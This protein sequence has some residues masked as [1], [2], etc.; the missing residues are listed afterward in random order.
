MP[1]TA[2][3]RRGLRR[4]LTVLALLPLIVLLARQLPLLPYAPLLAFYGFAVLTATVAVFYLAYAR[5]VD[6]AE[7]PAQPRHAAT[8]PPL[9]PSPTVSLLVAV[10]DEADGIEACVRS[11]TGSGYRPLQVIVVDDGSTDGTAEVLDRLA[12]ELPVTVLHLP[13]NV[14][15]KRALVHAARH[16]TGEVLAFTDSDCVLAPD[17]VGRCV[18]ALLRQPDLGAVSGHARALN[19]DESLLSRVQDVWY[20]GQFRVSKAAEASFGAVTCVSGPLAVFRREAVLNYLPAWAADRFLGGEFRFATDRQLTGYVLGQRWIGDRLKRRFADS[21]FVR[22][23]DHPPRAWRVGYVRSAK[24]WTTVP[25]RLRPF[26]RQQTRWKK[27]YVRN[28]FFTGTF[29]WRRGP[30]PAALYYGHALWVA[31]APAMAFSH[32][33]WAPLRG[34][35]AVPLLYLCGVLLKGTAWGLAYRLDNPGDP[36]WAYRPLMS[37][38]SATVLSWLLPWSVGTIRRGV[39]SRST[40]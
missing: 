37:V 5:Y 36:R 1:A 34:W 27:S 24:V 16:A 33:V 10:K 26:L 25:A 17:A 19:P 29:M 9:P 8:F 21:P 32:L 31:L 3:V 14:G 4:L 6:P 11:M 7:A 20:E 18:E 2:P 28:L 30:G 40:V 23:E 35:W 15:K 38:L 12:A 22:D 39:W 13:R